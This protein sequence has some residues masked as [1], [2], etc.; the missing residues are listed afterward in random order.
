MC[1]AR[2]LEKPLQES[3]EESQLGRKT[4]SKPIFCPQAFPACSCVQDVLGRVAKGGPEL[5]VASHN[6]ASVEQALR[7]MHY[8]G[9]SRNNTGK[10][11]FTLLLTPLCK[12]QVY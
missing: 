3:F 9:L 5:M 11:T 12:V 1:P 6:Q 8:H 4:S 7:A 10:L 2:Y